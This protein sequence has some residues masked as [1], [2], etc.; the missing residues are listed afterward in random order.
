VALT[1]LLLVSADANAN[2]D[3]D[4]TTQMLSSRA[5]EMSKAC[6]YAD[7][8][9]LLKLAAEDAEAGEHSSLSFAAVTYLR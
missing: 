8:T 5:C 3:D 1:A 6:V 4:G 9:T 2:Y 7:T